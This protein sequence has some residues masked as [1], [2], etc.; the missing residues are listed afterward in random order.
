MNYI[1]LFAGAGGLSEG[2]IRAGYEPVA[3]VEM[4]PNACYTLKTRACY[5]FLR[6]NGG[7]NIYRDY[8]RGDITRDQLYEAV[9]QGVIDSVICKEISKKTIDGI[10]A[11]IDQ[12]IEAHPEWEGNVDLIIGGPPCQAY[13]ILGRAIK[14]A[15]DRELA[16]EDIMEDP[17]NFLYKMYC[18]F[19]KKYHP[20]MFV[21]ENVPGILSAGNGKYFKNIQK[22]LHR[23]G[24][25]TEAKELNSSEYGVLQNRKRII[26]VGWLH[27]TG[28]TYPDLEKVEHNYKVKDLFCGL[29]ALESGQEINEYTHNRLAKTYVG[30][31]GIRERGD[32]LTQHVARPQINRDREIYR[33]TI[34]AWNNGHT[35]LKYSELPTE[36]I[37]HKNT[38]NF[39]DRFKV[40]E[41]DLSACHTMIAHISKDGHYFIHP[42]IEQARSL[43][44]REAA[45][46]QSF[47]DSY[48]FEGGRTAAFTQIG[49]A[50]PPLMAEAIARSIRRQFLPED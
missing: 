7:L 1:D 23:L 3:H 40:V 26:I 20:A 35:R 45:R 5:H 44:V 41:G 24:Y 10:F 34:E 48:Y 49:N 4:N 50:V 14:S 28:H 31:Y 16:P 11:T 18:R 8:L 47:P 13:S 39:L 2:F 30:E 32:I 9:P 36:L 25:E 21:F 27:G 43:S 12:R 15:K 22:Y 19:L 42:D 37:T 38:K 29:P 17:R 6:E 46:V 33:K